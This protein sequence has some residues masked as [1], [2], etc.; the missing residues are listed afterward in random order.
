MLIK[1][2][3]ALRQLTQTFV[4]WIQRFFPGV[5]M[6]GVLPFHPIRL[7]GV[8]KDNLTF[9]YSRYLP[10]GPYCIYIYLQI[11]EAYTVYSK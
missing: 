5:R 1:S 7:H 10:K 8:D 9:Y 6:G 4:Q 3:P 11:L 2:T